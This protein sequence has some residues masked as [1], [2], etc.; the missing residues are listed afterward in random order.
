[1]IPDGTQG[2]LCPATLYLR[3]PANVLP[4]NSTPGELC[5]SHIL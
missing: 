1:M 2:Y 5:G 4:H 3:F